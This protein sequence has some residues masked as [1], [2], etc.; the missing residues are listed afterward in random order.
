MRLKK[1]KKKKAKERVLQRDKA[2]EYQ[3]DSKHEKDFY[4]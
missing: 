2:K 4:M 3:R 1:Q